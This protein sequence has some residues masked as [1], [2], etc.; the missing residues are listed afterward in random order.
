MLFDIV[1]GFLIDTPFQLIA[2]AIDLRFAT[3][4]ICKHDDSHIDEV[5]DKEA[6]CA[7]YVDEFYEQKVEQQVGEHGE[8]EYQVS[9]EE[10]RSYLNF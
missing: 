5:K 7:I 8:Q 4:P 6:K 1:I 10:Q 9:N 2:A 3:I